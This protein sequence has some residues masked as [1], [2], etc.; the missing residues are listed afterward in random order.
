MACCSD[1]QT[2][3]LKVVTIGYIKSFI[4]SLIQNSTGG[5]VTV[6]SAF[7]NDEYCPTYQQLTDGTVVQV[8]SYSSNPRNDVDG[9]GVAATC[10][11]TGVAYSATQVVN[12]ADLLVYY[13]RLNELSVS[14]SKSVGLSEC[15]E[16]TTLTTTYTYKRYVKSMNNLCEVPTPTS[17]TEPGDCQNDVI[18]YTDFMGLTNS[19]STATC[20]SY[21]VGKN[22]SV[23]AV[24]RCDHVSGTTTFR[25]TSYS[26]NRLEICQNA[27]TGSCSS[28]V[29][30]YRV[31]TAFTGSSTTTAFTGCETSAYTATFT[32]YYDV[33][34][35]KKWVD[36]CGVDYPSIT[37]SAKTSDSGSEVI[38]SI[39]QNWEAVE[40]PTEEQTDNSAITYTYT[41]TNYGVTQTSWPAS[42][43]FTR[44]CSQSCIS[45]HCEDLYY[46]QLI[47]CDICK[48]VVELKYVGFSP[49]PSQGF[50]GRI[51]IAS[52]ICNDSNVINNVTVSYVGSTLGSS[53]ITVESTPTYTNVN[54]IHIY[55]VAATQN[56]TSSCNEH[57]VRLTYPFDG[58]TCEQDFTFKQAGVQCQCSP[59]DKLF[60][61]SWSTLDVARSGGTFNVIADRDTCFGADVKLSIPQEYL[62]LT[63]SLFVDGS[64]VEYDYGLDS[65]YGISG[66]L[67]ANTS[68]YAWDIPIVATASG[69]NGN[70]TSEI[71]VH[72]A[73]S[74]RCDCHFILSGGTGM[75]PG[76]TIYLSAE[77]GEGQLINLG[78]VGCSTVEVISSSVEDAQIAS[79]RSVYTNAYLITANPNTTGAQR[80]TTLRFI[81]KIDNFKEHPQYCTEDGGMSLSTYTIDY[82]LVQFAGTEYVDLGLTSKTLWSTTNVNAS[83]ATDYGQYYQWGKGAR[84]FQTTSAETIYVP[85]SEKLPLSAD[86]AN[87]VLGANWMMPTNDQIN[88]LF[89]NTNY[90]W[91]T[92]YNGSGINGGKFISKT[93]S[94]K[95]IFIPAGGY[96]HINGGSASLLS[97]GTVGVVLSN[98]LISG[99]NNK[100]NF[101]MFNSSGRNTFNPYVTGEIGDFSDGYTIRPVLKKIV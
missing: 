87:Q 50:S 72:Q 68:S 2:N 83:S 97:G 74:G 23:S 7:S 44:T 80:S 5:T 33:W 34:E 101:I 100:A 27:L 40:C 75:P 26:T 88:E 45:C 43:S 41:D 71:Y 85:T 1:I 9:I 73:T 95:F 10:T 54:E 48:Y 29:S 32:R 64:V 35:I 31:T 63:P 17:T 93:D 58:A 67:V 4:D 69:C 89:T 20:T 49:I 6:S 36:S 79:I 38:T 98:E 62:D 56:N 65:Y 42:V 8:H 96:W 13:T 14:S 91:V 28:V 86:S 47:G 25:G 3:C 84:N 53:S 66:E 55:A 30:T 94:S 15:G 11:E 92:N 19:G 22:G 82:N 12:Q 57:T 81:A 16:A 61:V 78:Q 90:E 99:V 39:T 21:T 70:C 52:G 77:G 18:W 60:K 37:C 24:S 59:S 46:S 51:E 76:D